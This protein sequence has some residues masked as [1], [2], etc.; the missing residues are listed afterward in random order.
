MAPRESA[1]GAPVSPLP[2]RQQQRN[3][4]CFV[5]D[6]I[7]VMFF[8]TCPLTSSRAALSGSSSRLAM[9]LSRDLSALLDIPLTEAGGLRKAENLSL[10]Q[11]KPSSSVQRHRRSYVELNGIP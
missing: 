10:R 11:T 2:S 1:R 9:R 6:A 3:S 7:V 5:F 8:L 4:R